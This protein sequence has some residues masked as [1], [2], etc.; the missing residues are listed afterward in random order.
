MGNIASSVVLLSLWMSSY[1]DSD[2][3]S[4]EVMTFALHA[5][6]EKSFEI[7]CK[8]AELSNRSKEENHCLDRIF[9]NNYDMPAMLFAHHQTAAIFGYSEFFD[10]FL[11]H[12]YITI[13]RTNR[14]LHSH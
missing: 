8:L 2:D 1:Q 6:M 14:E 13:T 12:F 3:S 9:S 7:M 10:I 4:S 5:Y 11:T